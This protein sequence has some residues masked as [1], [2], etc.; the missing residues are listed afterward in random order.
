M[1][2]FLMFENCMMVIESTKGITPDEFQ[3][4]HNNV[5]EIIEQF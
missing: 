4:Y 5:L 2:G 1:I 3:N